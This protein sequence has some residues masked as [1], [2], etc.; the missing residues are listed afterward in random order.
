MIIVNFR[1]KLKSRKEKLGF[2]LILKESNENNIFV[3]K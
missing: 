3:S 2:A 1:Q